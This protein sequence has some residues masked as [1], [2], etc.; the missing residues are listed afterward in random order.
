MKGI[1]AEPM[2]K[3]AG[4]KRDY[5]V[6]EV[7]EKKDRTNRKNKFIPN[8]MWRHFWEE[9]ER[10]EI[11]VPVPQHYGAGLVSRTQWLRSLRLKLHR[12]VTS[13]KQVIASDL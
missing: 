2:E 9:C 13:F 10:Q 12:W 4:W 3:G 5:M 6:G 8:K 11:G 1:G 7:G